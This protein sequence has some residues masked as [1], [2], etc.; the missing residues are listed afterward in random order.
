MSPHRI[1]LVS[2]ILLCLPV[3]PRA[4]GQRPSPEKAL[5]TDCYGDP[6]P[7]GALSRMGTVRF[8]PGSRPVPEPLAPD[9]NTLVLAPDGKTL[10]TGEDGVVRFWDL[11]TGQETRS[12]SLPDVYWVRGVTFS[13]DGKRLAVIGDHK[14]SYRLTRRDYSLFVCDAA[15]GRILYRFRNDEGGFRWPWFSPDG[16]LLAAGQG[17]LD[18]RQSRPKMVF[19]EADTGK[20]VR[21][22]DGVAWWAWSPDGK[23]L[24]GQTVDFDGV[25]LWEVGTGTMVRTL[26]GHELADTLFVFSP[27]GKTLAAAADMDVPRPAGKERDMVIY[28]WD[29]TAGK[30]RRRI[31]ARWHRLDQLAFSPDGTALAAIDLASGTLLWD[32]ATGKPRDIKGSGLEESVSGFAFSP[33]STT[34]YASA[35]GG[36]RDWDVR[37]GRERRK[38]DDSLEAEGRFLVTPNGKRLISDG[39]VVGVWDLTTGKRLGPAGGHRAGI[40]RL[41]FSPDGRALATLDDTQ[42]LGLWAVATGKPLA[43]SLDGATSRCVAMNLAPE[44]RGLMAVGHDATVRTWDLSTGRLAREFSAGGESTVRGW[45]WFFQGRPYLQLGCPVALLSPEGRTLA[46]SDDRGDVQFW[47]TTQ[48]KQQG[49]LKR[50]ELPRSIAFSA[51]GRYFALQAD[52]N[53]VQVWDTKTSKNRSDCQSGKGCRSFLFSPDERLLAWWDDAAVRLR[54]LGTGKQTVLLAA[55]PDAQDLATF[56]QGSQVFAYW[57]SDHKLAL[58]DASQ[59]VLLRTVASCPRNSREASFIPTHD[60]RA[61]VY[62][63]VEEERPVFALRDVLTGREICQTKS[64]REHFAVSPDGRVL[65]EAGSGIVF[66]ELASGTVLGQIEQA[67]RGRVKALNFSPD[68][69]ILA[70]AGWD[71]TLL[72][73]DWAA[74]LGLTRPARRLAAAEL[75]AA[76]SDLAGQDAARAC[77][78]IGALAGSPE[79]TVPFLREHLRPATAKEQATIRRRVADLDSDVFEVREN[80]GRELASLGREAD[81]TLVAALTANPSAEARVRTERILSGGGMS[82]RPSEPLRRSRSVWALERIGD[83]AARSLL[84]D[85]AR[86][87]PEALLTQQAKGALSRLAGRITPAP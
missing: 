74:A 39:A 50:K 14:E 43:P 30:E 46:I 82:R 10:V 56:L 21:V 19:W 31:T 37:T 61:L 17:R 32:A 59:A 34:L 28:L 55:D 78:A 27:D 52:D 71:T 53:I 80:A 57:D 69:R 29:V 20:K 7:P 60:G 64:W 47:E 79:N 3:A 18:S 24:A 8:H 83:T 54:D 11:A 87:E 76:W 1:G 36:L 72:T 15:T 38:L 73:W 13:P 48:G 45:Q 5:R 41:L 66:R 70:T 62:Y 49:H 16:K 68:G 4:C 67:H 51:G 23:A 86:G 40:E 25:H 12:F 65:V 77:K 9:G 26:P 84:E 81:A 35:A 33:D 42:A 63:S 22:L 6:L 2:L 58:C 85:L 44:G 75:D